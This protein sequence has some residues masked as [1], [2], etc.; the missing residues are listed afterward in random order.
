MTREQVL[1]VVAP[2]Q[3]D[4]DRVLAW[5]Q[6]YTPGVASVVSYGD[7]LVVTAD[8]ATAERM[9]SARLFVVKE[10]LSGKVGVFLFFF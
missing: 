6:S 7:A 9:L 10:A 5:A 3:A 1:A 8:V 2:L 4:H